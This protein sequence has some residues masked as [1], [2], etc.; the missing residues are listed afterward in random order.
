MVTGGRNYDMDYLDSCEVLVEGTSTNKWRIIDPLPIRLRN[1][2]GVTIDNDILM[3]GEICQKYVM[4][5]TIS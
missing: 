4:N 3:T 5:N 2:R 1:H